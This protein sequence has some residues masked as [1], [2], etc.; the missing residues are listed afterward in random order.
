VTK[1]QFRKGIEDGTVESL[2]NATPVKDGQCYYLPSGTVH[3]LGAGIFAAEV[4]TPSDTTFRVF[5]F[6][7]IEAATG[8]PRTLHIEQALECIDFTGQIDKQAEQKRSHTAGFHTTVSR[9]VTSPY[10]TIEKVRMSEGV[11][12]AVPYDEPVVWMFLEGSAE[13]R[14]ADMKEP[15]TL[16][17]GETIL[18]PASMNNPQIKT[19]GDCV[20]LE[21]T[22]P[23]KGS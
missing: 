16:K 15:V 5:D 23:T 1:E 11:E 4:Q 8:K 2:I 18:L 6:N 3:A 10:F 9:L 12:E 19:L 7:R 22:F 13:L 14:V 21:V 17:K 20:W